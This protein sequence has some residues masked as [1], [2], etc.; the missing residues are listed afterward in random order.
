M[1]QCKFGTRDH[2]SSNAAAPRGSQIG[3][4]HKFLNSCEPS[5]GWC[6]FLFVESGWLSEDQL[7]A[8]A[9][10]SHTRRR[11]VLKKILGGPD[12][13]LAVSEMDI[14]ILQRQFRHYFTI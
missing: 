14:E 3:K 6:L 7:R 10:W 9:S 4:V 5:M 12:G 2:A 1:S 13:Q 11:T 8:V